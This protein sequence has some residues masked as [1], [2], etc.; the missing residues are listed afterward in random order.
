MGSTIG[1]IGNYYKLIQILNSI[2][3]SQCSVNQLDY[4]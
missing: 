3:G 4:N 2:G 1:S